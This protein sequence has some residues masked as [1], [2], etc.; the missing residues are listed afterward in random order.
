MLFCCRVVDRWQMSLWD[1]GDRWGRRRWRHVIP[2]KSVLL[3]VQLINDGP[4]VSD[5]FVTQKQFMLPF[6][7]LH[8]L[9]QCPFAANLFPHILVK[10]EHVLIHAFCFTHSVKLLAYAWVTEWHCAWA[11]RCQ[12]VLAKCKLKV[13]TPLRLISA[14]IIKKTKKQSRKKLVRD[15]SH[16]LLMC[17]IKIRSVVYDNVVAEGQN[18]ADLS[19]LP[20]K[21]LEYLKLLHWVTCSLL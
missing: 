12:I 9:K 19:S 21:S 7:S 3:N 15:H 20:K 2:L 8:L 1:K 16:H 18:G 13:S 11:H 14:I 6:Q 17:Y 10:I 5:N 4:V